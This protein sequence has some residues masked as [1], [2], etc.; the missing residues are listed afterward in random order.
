M[1]RIHCSI[2]RVDAFAVIAFWRILI[3][4]GSMYSAWRP[5]RIQ[6]VSGANMAT[7]HHPAR[8]L[9]QDSQLNAHACCV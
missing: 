7:S 4:L 9:L 8:T 5:L 1:P 2:H 3:W 6:V